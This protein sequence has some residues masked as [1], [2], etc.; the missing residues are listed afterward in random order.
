MSRLYYLMGA[1]GVGKD[2]LL[3]YL[4]THLAAEDRVMLPQRYITRPANAGG[5]PH[6]ELSVEAFRQCLARGGF[7]MHWSSH[8]FHYGINREIDEWLDR[9]YQVVIN[10]SRH[11]LEK[12]QARYPMLQPVLIRVSHDTL[13]ERLTQ[14]GRESGEEIEQRLQR[15]E[16]LDRQLRQEELLI[17]N[18]DGPLHEAGET[19]RQLILSDESGARSTTSKTVTL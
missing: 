3:D 17:L 19:L 7:A 16:A 6:I 14:R 5:E 18:N 2:S 4:R 11:Y 8:G 13:F 12:A 10:G 9:D 1:S 15:A